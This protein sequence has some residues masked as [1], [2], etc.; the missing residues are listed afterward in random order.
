MISRFSSLLGLTVDVMSLSLSPIAHSALARPKAPS[1]LKEVWSPDDLPLFEPQSSQSENRG[2]L[3]NEQHHE[4]SD[5]RLQRDVSPPKLDTPAEGLSH[6]S[7]RLA[8]SHLEPTS[9]GNQPSHATGTPGQT[10]GSTPNQINHQHEDIHHLTGLPAPEHRLRQQP[11]HTHTGSDTHLR[12]PIGPSPASSR[13]TSGHNRGT[14]REG[15]AHGPGENVVR[16]SGSRSGQR[17]PLPE[18]PGPAPFPPPH[19]LPQ[20]ERPLPH[21][22]MTTT[23]TN[24]TESQHIQPTSDLDDN[25]INKRGGQPVREY[26]STTFLSCMDLDFPRSRSQTSFN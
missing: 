4:R 25:L 14:L 22:Q 10:S 6:H 20:V 7:P 18:P 2:E 11:P 19:R 15:N 21:P 12:S 16:P 13:D 1:N 24:Q 17:F 9:S 5:P 3:P 26:S 23:N 8:G